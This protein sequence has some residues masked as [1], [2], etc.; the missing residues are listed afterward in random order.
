V[1]DALPAAWCP[2][3]RRPRFGTVLL[4]DPIPDAVLDVDTARDMAAAGTLLVAS[5]HSSE[6]VEMVIKAAAPR[7][8][9]KPVRPPRP[10]PRRS[11]R[12]DAPE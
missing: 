5:R 9:P 4:W 6:M 2:I 12:W 1:I 7:P 10:R 8:P 11:T 3:A